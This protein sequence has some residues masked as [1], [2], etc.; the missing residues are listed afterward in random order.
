MVANHSMYMTKEKEQE[1]QGL[2]KYYCS[3]NY[4][5][6][7]SSEDKKIRPTSNFSAP[8][9]SGSFNLLAI[10]GPIIIN[11][12]K[13]ML[14][15]FFHFS[16]GLT[17]DI[18]KAYRSIWLTPKSQSL[19]RFFWVENKDDITSMKECLWTKCTYGSGPTGIYMEIILREPV[20][21]STS[22]PEV[23]ALLND[24]RFVDTLERVIM[25]PKDWLR[26]LKSI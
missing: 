24:N 22:K 25:N 3:L 2:P 9:V 16:H 10:N 7:N 13:K 14:I 23:K 5:K 26:K 11:S 8:H 6:K 20:S 19:S 4:V 1:L 15:K 17:V 18:S 12:S 21:E